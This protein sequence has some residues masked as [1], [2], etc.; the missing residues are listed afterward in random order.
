MGNEE[1]DD[2][3]S[4]EKGREGSDGP[5]DHH[6]WLHQLQHWSCLLVHHSNCKVPKL[7]YPD[8]HV[9]AEQVECLLVGDSDASLSPHA[10][11]IQFIDTFATTTAMRYS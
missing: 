1:H 6:S 2:H 4:Y 8:G 9:Q 7:E 10:M 11:M 3:E 5:Y